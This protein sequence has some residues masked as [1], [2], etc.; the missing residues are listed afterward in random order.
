MKGTKPDSHVSGILKQLSTPWKIALERARRIKNN[1]LS[2]GFI[3]DLA[4]GSGIQ[5]AAYSYE[6]N[7][8]CIGIE[9]N[10]ERAE[11]AKKSLN[12][13]L[14]GD[15]ANKSE[16][17]IGNSL[18]K[19]EIKLDEKIN[20]SLIHLDPA[21]PTDIQSHTISEM[22]PPPIKTI[23]IW[24]D[25]LRENGGIILDLSPRLSEEQCKELKQELTKILPDYKQTWEWASQGRGRV[26]R[27]SVWLGSVASKDKASRYV[28]NHPNDIEKSIIV[29]SNKL[30]WNHNNSK[31]K[32]INANIGD[33]ISIIDAALISSGLEDMWLKSQ[34]FEGNWLR[35]K[36]RRPLYLHSK[37][38]KN[39]SKENLISESGIIRTIIDQDI[40]KGV[41]PLIEIGNKLGF[42]KLTLRLKV[43]PDLQPIFQSKLDK[44][45]V[46]LG[47]TGFVIKLPN[48]RLAVCT[49][50]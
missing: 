10:P 4:C 12:S 34:N 11:I 33:Y 18:K 14:E 38:I 36:G 50:I 21:R 44:N 15:I 42:K 35:K 30:P 29:E 19:S 31:L 22:Q 39:D 45:L 24:K 47:D 40:N 41:E 7:R 9:I 26:D 48:N 23:E 16:I 28:R 1:D 27:L 17:I 6:L 5:L 13:I 49:K 3:L 2:D 46:D 8:P 32:E 20:F 37:E 25:L 43:L